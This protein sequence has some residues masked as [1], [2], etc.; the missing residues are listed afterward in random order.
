[1]ADDKKEMVNMAL[2]ALDRLLRM[3]QVERIVYLLLTAVSFVMLLFAGYQLI[4]DRS[5]DT[6]AMV[7]VFGSTGLVTASSA[8]VSHFFHRAFT[9]VE[10]LIQGLSKHE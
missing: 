8:R 6:T 1:M 4:A 5:M 3:F 7:A 10:G 2:D 9:L